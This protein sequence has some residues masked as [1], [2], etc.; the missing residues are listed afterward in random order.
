LGANNNTIH[1]ANV[2]MEKMFLGKSLS[3]KASISDVFNNSR[4][5]S[6]FASDTY[7]TESVNLGMRRYFL[8]SLSYRIKKFGA[9]A[10]VNPF[11]GLMFN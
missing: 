4:N 11:S 1:T 5:S 10:T 7:I 2:S 6:R 3:L 9:K 8:M